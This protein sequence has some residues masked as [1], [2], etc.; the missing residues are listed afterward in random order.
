MKWEE[1]YR[2]WLL[3]NLQHELV[4][5]A[6]RAVYALHWCVRAAVV[7]DG[8]FEGDFPFE[9]GHHKVPIQDRVGLVVR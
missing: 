5:D 3:K 7:N 8:S 2:I 6:V 9:H 4:L 1:K